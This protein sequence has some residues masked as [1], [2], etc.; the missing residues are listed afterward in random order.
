MHVGRNCQLLQFGLALDFVHLRLLR[1]A[2]AQS[3]DR[4]PASVIQIMGFN[5]VTG[6]RVSFIICLIFQAVI[7]RVILMERSNICKDIPSINTS[8]TEPLFFF[9]NSFF[10]FSPPGKYPLRRI[11]S[12]CPVKS[13]QAKLLI[14]SQKI[15]LLILNWRS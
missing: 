3:E 11:R 15:T 10:F 1:I 7:G 12:I 13:L 5:P 4:L 9:L 2:I 14:I 6:G 8:V